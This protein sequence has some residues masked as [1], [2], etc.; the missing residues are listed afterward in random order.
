MMMM[1]MSNED[2]DDDIGV[3][4]G[5]WVTADLMKSF[6]KYDKLSNSKIII[7]ITMMNLTY[8]TSLSIFVLNK[9]KKEIQKLSKII[10]NYFSTDSSHNIKSTTNLLSTS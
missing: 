5:I 3:V 8:L 10:Q 9:E 2:D 1:M 6:A 7:D 4:E